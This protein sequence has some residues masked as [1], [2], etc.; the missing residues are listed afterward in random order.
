MGIYTINVKTEGDPYN[1]SVCKA[2]SE[3]DMLG[4]VKNAIKVQDILTVVIKKIKK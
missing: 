1:Q 2:N 4:I 3:E